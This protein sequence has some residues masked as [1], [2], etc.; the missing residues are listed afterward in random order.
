MLYASSKATLTKTLGAAQFTDSVYATQAAE[1][2][3][4]A[5]K[6]HLVSKTTD[7][8]LSETE[9]MLAQVK[10]EELQAEAIMQRRT[11]IPS[12]RV[13]TPMDPDAM[14]VVARF[15]KDGEK[16]GLAVFVGLIFRAP[17]IYTCG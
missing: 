3:L 12:A 17:I 14:A 9:K 13:S 1:L 16:L 11:P 8:P 4:D 7:A 10:M 15:D 2:T 6:K 5:Y